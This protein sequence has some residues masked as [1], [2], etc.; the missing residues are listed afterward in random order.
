MKQNLSGSPVS[1]GG[2]GRWAAAGLC[3]LASGIA[4]SC[5]ARSAKGPEKTNGVAAPSVVGVQGGVN[6]ED[7]L[8]APIPSDAMAYRMDRPKPAPASPKPPESG[9]TAASSAPVVAPVVAGAPAPVPAVVPAAPV[10][11]TLADLIAATERDRAAHPNDQ[12]VRKRLGQLYVLAGRYPEAAR[13]F[14]EVDFA[15]DEF[16]RVTY[17]ALMNRLGEDAK[18]VEALDAVRRSWRRSHELRLPVA[19]F[20]QGGIAG[21]RI[22][23]PVEQA[24]FFRGRSVGVY[25]EV[26]NFT[27]RQTAGGKYQVA[28]RIDFAILDEAKR[29][30][31]WPD[32]ARYKKDFRS[33]KADDF[34]ELYIPLL[35]V[36]P[37]DLAPGSYTLSLKVRDT[38]GDKAAETSLPFT[39][40]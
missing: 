33:E 34:G 21:Y 9:T 22:Y 38:L 31:P 29:P 13:T 11:P 16:A 23:S 18:A 39:V 14:E 36:F 37:K 1:R 25:V 7:P 6:D 32:L 15:G 20:T 5:A 8:L 3:L 19:C 40:Q 24:S 35:V 26:E 2:A 27:S 17:A 12:G 4:A 30:V 10:E 28:L